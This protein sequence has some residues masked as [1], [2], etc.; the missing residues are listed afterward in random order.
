MWPMNIK[1][2][3]DRLPHFNVKLFFYTFI[4]SSPNF[5]H[6]NLKQWRHLEYESG[7]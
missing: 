2:K 1:L 5:D 4:V 3:F 6:K 7:G